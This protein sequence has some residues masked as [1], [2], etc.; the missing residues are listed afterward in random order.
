MSARPL[1][2]RMTL[3]PEDRSNEEHFSIRAKLVAGSE[4]LKS[5]FGCERFNNA[6]DG[7]FHLHCAKKMI[8]EETT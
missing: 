3:A 1:G 7:R 2:E 5:V 8:P 4:R 6:Q